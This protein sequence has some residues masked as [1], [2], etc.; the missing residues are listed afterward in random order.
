MFGSSNQKRNQNP[1]KYH[2][3]KWVKIFKNGSS[4]IF[5]GCL[6]QILL[7]P[8]LNTLAHMQ[9]SKIQRFAK[10]VNSSHSLTIFEKS[11]ILD[12]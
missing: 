6:P 10:V 5:K 1:V 8:F 11:S 9:I 2:S 12:I 3:H 7:G 4:K